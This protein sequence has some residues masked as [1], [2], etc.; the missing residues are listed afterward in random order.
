M[1]TPN[2]AKDFPSSKPVFPEAR[3][4]I[5]APVTAAPPPEKQYRIYNT[6][7][8]TVYVVNSDGTHC[9]PPR[10][11]YDLPFSKISH[12]IKLM[13]RRGFIRLFEK[14]EKG[15]KEEEI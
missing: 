12:H 14:G 8:Q 13:A 15:E 5:P 6:S 2:E 1:A 3:K 7:G 4:E 10:A 9:L 11:Y